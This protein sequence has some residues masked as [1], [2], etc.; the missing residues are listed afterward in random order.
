MAN[1]FIFLFLTIAM[2][3]TDDNNTYTDDK[4]LNSGIYYENI[5]KI[6]LTTDTFKLIT[7]VNTS[8]YEK[9][10]NDLINI[11]E[12]TTMFCMIKSIGNISDICHSFNGL[13]NITILQ[14]KKSF[15]TYNALKTHK[16]NKRGL[17][18]IVGNFEKWAFGILDEND[19]EE[20]DNKIKTNTGKNK[21]TLDIIN[22]QT[23]IIQSSLNNINN[24]SDT[25]NDNTEKLKVTLENLIET[26]NKNIIQENI[27]TISEKLTQHLIFFNII[28][29]EFNQETEELIE[30][31][32]WGQTGQLHPSI[33]SPKNIIQ[34][35]IEVQK[36]IPKHLTFPQNPDEIINFLDFLKLMTISI[37]FRD[38]YII[39]TIYIPLCEIDSYTMYHII[40][41][42]ISLIN[43]N[44]IFIK[45]SIEYLAIS[46]DNE[47]FVTF[48]YQ[49]YIMCKHSLIITVC[50]PHNTI[51]R[52]TDKTCEIQLYLDPQILPTTCVI[53]HINT[54]TTFYKKLN[55][56][57]S[58]L[59]ASSDIQTA[60]IVCPNKSKTI[61]I[62]G[63]GIISINKQCYI[64]TTTIILKPNNCINNT[65]YNI[66][67][68]P[69]FHL[70]NISTNILNK[71]NKIQNTSIKTVNLKA[72]DNQLTEMVKTSKSLEST[73]NLIEMEEDSIEKEKN[74]TNHIYL[75]YIVGIIVGYIIIH[76]ILK[77]IKNKCRN[78][79][80][81]NNNDNRQI[82]RFWGRQINMND[83]PI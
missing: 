76:I 59:Y 49:N 74:I 38:T 53:G 79:F 56:K 68:I 35:L 82:N 6:K 26:V 77:Y 18:N 32:M 1:K 51:N 81:G 83:R 65:S 41:F 73:I 60:T 58:W 17:I 11:Y 29:S 37:N 30:S 24:I 36:I 43:N 44:Y 12:G 57:N 72:I 14:L 23:R 66:D 13:L 21:K 78:Y 8:N 69:Q 10:Y 46:Q 63:T 2:V 27:I 34:Q 67:F 20:I 61:K 19:L 9:K 33:I 54:I 75:L 71:L 25:I 52:N 4:I 7:I 15:N 31:V 45:S 62:S 64:K 42:P 16:I 5:S 39:Y 22:L 3:K 28:L 50:T 47:K 48:T 80:L 40:P 70:P 55:F